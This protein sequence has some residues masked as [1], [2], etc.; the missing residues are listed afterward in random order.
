MTISEMTR[1][2]EESKAG[3]ESNPITSNDMLNEFAKLDGNFL[4]T[5]DYQMSTAGY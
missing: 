3:L 2:V 5:L 4:A 1:F